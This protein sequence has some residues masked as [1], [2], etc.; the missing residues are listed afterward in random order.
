[1]V[2]KVRK[3]DRSSRLVSTAIV[4]LIG[5]V[6]VLP[7]IWMLS[8]SLQINGD[9][10][11]YPFTWLPH[12]PR[13]VN[14][15]DIWNSGE[16]PL[17]QMYR[18]SLFIVIFTNI[19]VLFVSLLAAYAFARIE[20]K[21]KG[22]VFGLFIGVMMIPSQVTVV[23][24]FLL[25]KQLNIYNTLWAVILPGL[26]SVTSIFLM[27]QFFMTIPASLSESA[28]LDGAGHF[29][30][31][32]Q[33]MLPLLKPTVASLVIMNFVSCW[34]DYFNPLVFLPSKKWYTVSLG[35]Q[36]YYT[37]EVPSTNLTMAMSVC[38]ILP[39]LIL[40]FSCQRFFIESITSSGVKG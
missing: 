40:F 8:A 5:L 9:I 26:F 33:I 7:L 16:V 10:F 32:M 28:F 20:F 36:Y 15:A 23:P 39:V 34:N 38:A 18:N 29:R 11:K 27:R 6:F 19:G 30:I 17:L 14:Y 24:R 3:N 4:T 21:G 22:I 35:I 25:F 37:Q 12:A 13:W 2:S 31:L 1:M